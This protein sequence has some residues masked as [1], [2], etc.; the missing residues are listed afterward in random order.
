MKHGTSVIA[1]AVD[2][3]GHKIELIEEASLLDV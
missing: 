3:D 1:F 2:P